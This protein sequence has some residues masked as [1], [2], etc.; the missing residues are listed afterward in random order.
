MYDLTTNQDVF[1]SNV[2]SFNTNSLTW[3]IPANIKGTSPNNRLFINSV[4]D[5][6]GKM[7]IFGGNSNTT[8]LVFN[9]MVILDTVESTWSIIILA[10]SPNKRVGYTATLLSN[11]VIA[12]IGGWEYIENVRQ[13]VNIKQINLY[14]TKSSTWSMKVC[15]NVIYNLLIIPFLK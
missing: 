13:D 7:Y 4:M 11:G 14:D 3:N 10:N 12:Y 15:M 6:T 5:D 1:I 9:D 8:L 2:Y